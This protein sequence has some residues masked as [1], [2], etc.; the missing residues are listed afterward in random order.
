M[1]E[2]VAEQSDPSP[3]RPPARRH[4]LQQAPVSALDI[5][6]IQATT[7]GT[8]LFAVTTVILALLYDRLAATGNAWWLG[9]SVSGVVLGLIGL[10]YCRNRRRRRGAAPSP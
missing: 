9:V 8:I 1:V 3:D 5:D 7:T 2:D 4:L 6:G 10:V